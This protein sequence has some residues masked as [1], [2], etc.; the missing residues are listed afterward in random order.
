MDC[1]ACGQAVDDSAAACTSCG[2]DTRVTMKTAE[3]VVY[4]PYTLSDVRSFA[5]LGRVPIGS[6]LHTMDGQTLTLAQVGL[7]AMVAD[8]AFSG[9][10]RPGGLGKGTKW[11]MVL[12]ILAVALPIVG[13]GAVMMVG[14]GKTAFTARGQAQENICHQQLTQ[15]A[16]SVQL[17][18]EAHGGVLPN[19]ATWKEDIAPYLFGDD[20]VFV[21]PSSGLGQ[22]SYEFNSA[23]S[24]RAIASISRRDTIPM[25]Y[26]TGLLQNRGPHRG[27]GHVIYVS[28]D[29]RW[30]PADAL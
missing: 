19:S 11:G 3:G 21:C 27:G 2:Q 25:I 8:Q 10:V 30:V 18:A 13:V 16:L 17:Y 12:L 24:N 22:S 5:T 4:G 23:V 15:L 7:A 14:A 1:P 20:S 9:P 6:T 28:G 29:V 26:E